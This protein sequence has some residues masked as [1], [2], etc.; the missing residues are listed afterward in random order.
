MLNSVK[1]FV[2]DLID[3]YLLEMSTIKV[4]A[5]MDLVKKKEKNC[6]CFSSRSSSSCYKRKNV[7]IS[8][9]I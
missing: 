2:Y 7:T 1:V 3:G 6:K 9:I 4:F 5:L 8:I